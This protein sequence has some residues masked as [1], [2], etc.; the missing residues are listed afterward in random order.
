VSEP[1]P[2]LESEKES[3]GLPAFPTWRGVYAFVVVFF[4]VVVSLM[5]LLE[6]A[7]P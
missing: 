4:A 5:V 1:E 3:T 6:R 7:F 2:I